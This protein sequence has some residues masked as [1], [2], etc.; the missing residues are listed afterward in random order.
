VST[1][2]VAEELLSRLRSQVQERV[3]LEKAREI[4]EAAL[5]LTKDELDHLAAV[6]ADFASEKVEQ[7]HTMML[8][9]K[10]KDQVAAQS[11]TNGARP[12]DGKVRPY[13]EVVNGFTMLFP[14]GFRGKPPHGAS[15]CYH[16][17]ANVLESEHVIDCPKCGGKLGVR[18]RL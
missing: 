2:T 15:R 9:A 10:G 1:D 4:F 5:K 7:I 17:V 12:F 16:C 13:T 6:E 3:V 8:N 18:G 11:P 14:M